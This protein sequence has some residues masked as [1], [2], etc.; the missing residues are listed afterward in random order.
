[1]KKR[2]THKRKSRLLVGSL[3]SGAIGAAI[4]HLPQALR[5]VLMLGEKGGLSTKEIAAL[6]GVSTDSI[7]STQNR[8]IALVQ[9]ELLLKAKAAW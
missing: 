4:A 1:M 5:W 7:E 6:A 8:G 3:G 2:L 9:R